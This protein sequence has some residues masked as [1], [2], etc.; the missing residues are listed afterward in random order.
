MV[1]R[2]II[3]NIISFQPFNE[4]ICKLRLRGKYHNLTLIN[5]HAPTEDKDIR[6]K[7]QYYDDLQR[8]YENTAKHDVVT[9]LGDVNAKTGKEQAYSQASGRHILY[10]SSNQN[11]KMVHNFAIRNIMII[12]STQYQ[13]KRIHKG[14]WRAPDGATVNQIDHVLINANKRSVVEDVRSMSGL[15]CDSDLLLLKQ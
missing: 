7:E 2:E 9:I 8:V 12:M 13:H 15:K 14:T 6:V 3:K 4:K 11:G 10:D 5:V 1:K